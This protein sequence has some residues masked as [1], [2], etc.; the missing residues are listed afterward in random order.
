MP[1][2]ENCIPA[3]VQAL[4]SVDKIKIK[5]LL[6]KAIDEYSPVNTVEGIIVPALQRI[7]EDW[8]MGIVSLSQVYMSGIIC[9]NIL[10]TIAIPI[11]ETKKIQPKIA[12][13][14]FEDFHTLGKSILCSFL[15]ASGYE[16]TDYGHGLTVSDTVNRTIRDN[17]EVLMLSTLMLPAAL[18]IGAMKDALADRNFRGKL[19]VG[20]APFNF[21]T[22][23]YK[24]VGADYM[25]R[26]VSEAIDIIKEIGGDKKLTSGEYV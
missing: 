26:N 24:E 20:G 12:I 21:D 18:R 2:L 25:G 22:E 3:V 11:S 15:R 17:I 10:D 16:V 14:V 7:G 23:L 9:G 6:A 8:S 4:L 5:E 1:I 13:A 19:V